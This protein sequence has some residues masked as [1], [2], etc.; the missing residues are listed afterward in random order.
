MAYFELPVGDGTNYER[1]FARNPAVYAAWQQLNGAIKES[2]DLRLYEVATVAAAGE[3]RSSYCSLAHGKVLFERFGIAPGDPLDDADQA[4][5][6]LARKLV[7][8]ATAITQSDID[9][10]R[11]HGL[12]DDDVFG[13]VL[14]A[15]ARCFFSKTLDALG[16]QPDT[17]FRELPDEVREPLTVGR[18]IEG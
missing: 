12:S 6:R 7:D 9:E 15:A 8:D 1:L 2:I 11:A 4:V 3:L 13:V 5:Q 18:P 10:L 16:V 14:A 17:S